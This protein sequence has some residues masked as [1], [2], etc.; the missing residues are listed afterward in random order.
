MGVRAVETM[1]AS[2]MVVNPGGEVQMAIVI[3]IVKEY[4]TCR[5][6]FNRSGNLRAEPNGACQH[7]NFRS[8]RDRHSTGKGESHPL[9]TGRMQL[10]Y[11]STERSLS[12]EKMHGL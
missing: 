7:Y 8:D 10:G 4:H 2:F 9:H 5:L 6:P 11:M 3:M 1:T 12:R